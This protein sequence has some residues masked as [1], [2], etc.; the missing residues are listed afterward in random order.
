MS[1]YA[2]SAGTVTVCEAWTMHE[3]RAAITQVLNTFRSALPSNS[4]AR[5]VIKPNLN[6]DL[7]ALTGNSTDLRV[8]A[9]LVSE[10]QTRGYTNIAIADGPNVGVERRGINVFKRLRIDRLAAKFG[11]ELINLNQDD[12]DIVTLEGGA[13]PRIAY[14]LTEADF[15]ICAPTVKTHAEAGMSIA[16]KNWVGIVCGQ[17]K[18][19]MH[20]A[21][22][23]NIARLVAKF[24]PHLVIVD[25][26]V[27]MEGNG[28]GDGEPVRLGFIA[29][30]TNPWLCDLAVCRLVQFDWQNVT[31]LKYAVDHHLMDPSLPAEVAEHIP[32]LTQVTPAP[33]RNILAET[34]DKRSLFWLKKLARPLTSRKS[35]AELA[36]RAGIIQD[37]Y[38]LTDDTIT[39]V[40][41][42]PTTTETPGTCTDVCPMELTLD[43]G[44]AEHGPDQC[45][46]CLYCWWLC[47]DGS[48]ELVGEPNFMARQ[49]KRYKARVEKM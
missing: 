35:I 23:P 39:G 9:A 28:P 11:V 27:G 18:R 25:G 22:G 14:T 45:I 26:L 4:D 36:Y 2:F 32:H 37:V 6:N 3:V 21:L 13:T 42:V 46:N 19:Q 29:A 20:Y 38:D 47:D 49:I 10:L 33:V 40:K 24:P 31:Y 7:S 48:I 44:G 15:I 43:V 16:C 8:L 34:S 30:A 12:G 5:I 1:E 41:R 17:D